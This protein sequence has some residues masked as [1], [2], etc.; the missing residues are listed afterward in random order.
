MQIIRKIL[1]AN[2]GEIALRIMRTCK[3]R[4]IRTVAVFSDADQDAPFVPY[5]DEAWHLGASPAL[6]SYLNQEKILEAA[7][8]CGAD[9][10]HPGYGFLSE[11]AIFARKCREAGL[12]FIGPHP[13][14]I[15]QMGSKSNAK[16]L[17]KAHKVPV[18]P[19]YEGENQETEHLIKEAEKIGFPLLIKASAGGGGK[20]MHIVREPSG[21]KTALETAKREA[22]NSFGDSTLLLEK[23]FDSVRHI[24]FQIFGDDFGNVV[25]LFERECTIQRRHQKII[26]EAPSSFVDEDLRKKMGAAAVEAA[27]AIRYTNAGTVEFIV[28]ADKNF[29]FLEVNT[30]LQVEHPVTEAITGLDLVALQIDIA[31][32]KALPFGQEEIQFKGHALEYRLYAE[33]PQQDFQPAFGKILHWQ[34]PEGIRVDTGVQSGSEVTTF[35]DPMLAKIIVAGKDREEALRNSHYALEETCC[36]GVETNQEFLQKIIS[37][38]DFIKGNFDT[39][40]LEKNKRELQATQV[41]QKDMEEAVLAAMLYGWQERSPK[42]KI[43][44]RLLSGWRNNFYRPQEETY[45]LADQKITLYYNYLGNNE[46]EIAFESEAA[47]TESIELKEIGKNHV[48]FTRH[49]KYLRLMLVNKEEEVIVRQKNQYLHLIKAERHPSPKKALSKGDYKAPMPGEIVKIWVEEGQRVKNGDPLL[50]INSM[51][52]ENTVYAHQEGTIQGIFVSEKTLVNA[53]DVLLKMEEGEASS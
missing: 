18:V 5:A 37:H 16:K 7:L 38:K 1:V 53:G 30:R 40:F 52:M 9:A 6:E 20:G 4:F 21:L 51:K 45:Y 42:R 11:N 41:Q 29:Y 17:M 25:H 34:S 35:Y 13:E 22:M 15:L 43:L 10:I 32:G 39:H 50:V 46:F 12:I 3:Q 14:A 19:G 36:M 33:K 23:Y 31:Q 24:E 8:A 48:S 26:E 28:D 27:R 47:T 44:P 2:R 49:Q